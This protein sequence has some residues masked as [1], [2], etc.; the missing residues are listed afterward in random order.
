MKPGVASGLFKEL[1]LDPD[2]GD[3]AQKLAEAFGPCRWRDII[4]S[5]IKNCFA[6]SERMLEA[7]KT[8]LDLNG[9][10][11]SLWTK[12]SQK[13]TLLSFVLHSLSG[14]LEKLLKFKAAHLL[15]RS[16]RQTELPEDPYPELGENPNYLFG[17]PLMR[18]LL[19]GIGK[20]GTVKVF[21]DLYHAKRASLP[22]DGRFV[23]DACIKH[24]STLTGPLKEPEEEDEEFDILV[25]QV[26]RTVREAY[27]YRGKARLGKCPTFG[28]CVENPRY[29]GGSF[30]HLTKEFGPSYFLDSEL[31]GYSHYRT[32]VAEVR[33]PSLFW[34]DR[35][36]DHMVDARNEG[37]PIQCISVPLCEPFK[38]RMITRGESVRYHV[39]RMYQPLLHR[40]ISER[41]P[42]RLTMGPMDREHLQELLEKSRRFMGTS[43]G[44]WV[45]GDYA[46]ATDNLNPILSEVAMETACAA[47]KIPWE[48]RFLLRDALT[49]H[50]I[51]SA[52]DGS[53]DLQT[54]GQLMG[55]PVSF[56][57]LCLVNAAVCRYVSELSIGRKIKLCDWAG[58]VNGDDVLLWL[59][60]D[61]PSYDRWK[62]L[63]SKCGLVPSMGKNYTS[64]SHVIINSEI[65]KIH[66]NA[67]Y[68]GQ[69]Y[70]AIDEKLPL[71]NLG[72]L[73]G[74]SKS[75]SPLAREKTM[76]GSHHMQRDSIGQRCR[77][78]VD[79]AFDK[80]KACSLFIKKNKT[81]LDQLPREVNW[82]VHPSLG[83]LG[84]PVTREVEIP[85]VHRKIAGLFWHAD[86]P[87]V[88]NLSITYRQPLP[89]FVE[90]VMACQMR[91]ERQLGV[92]YAKVEKSAESCLWSILPGFI[93]LGGDYEEKEGR[94]NLTFRLREITKVA[95]S[96]WAEPL[97]FHNC[98]AG[99]SH[100]WGLPFKIRW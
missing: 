11:L 29:K 78:F 72:L 80:D 37:G 99:P 89:D 70:W 86:I 91:A 16:L 97:S 30:K 3:L 51:E 23:V 1:E 61:G 9:Y 53:C 36:S 63:T 8:V 73:Y 56:P 19:R 49:R 75:E 67:D 6:S 96:H 81:D 76:F 93:V 25:N 77:D 21:G 40:G 18:H 39:C 44:V 45:S 34:F 43:P 100:E 60:D 94:N 24:H 15:A 31:W 54:N 57:I 59:P 79:S 52:H 71:L 20:K 5:R 46:S 4:L 55:S 26:R 65:W 7:Y 17:G 58:L 69:T 64:R 95:L 98:I 12:R 2:A 22:V 68:F 38:V 66:H 90:S 87:E 92:R 88:R 74:E 50:N 41:H 32:Q 82:F 14:R 62:H 27:T 48:D 10:D 85:H 13:E 35:I 28:S 84:F 47:L 83:G 33:V 42:F